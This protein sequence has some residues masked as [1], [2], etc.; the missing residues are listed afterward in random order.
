MLSKI[1]QRASNLNELDGT[2]RRKLKKKLDK[3]RGSGLS[4]K[5]HKTHRRILCSFFSHES[6]NNINQ[7]MSLWGYLYLAGL[8]VISWCPH[9]AAHSD[10]HCPK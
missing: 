8:L 10:A 9:T 6:K 3:N 7:S 5:S 1:A 2:A 4:C